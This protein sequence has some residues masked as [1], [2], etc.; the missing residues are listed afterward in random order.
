MSTCSFGKLNDASPKRI[1]GKGA[2]LTLTRRNQY[3][4]SCMH[5]TAYC[6]L[7]GRNSRIDIGRYNLDY[8]HDALGF[9]PLEILDIA[10][11]SL[12]NG[13]FLTS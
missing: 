12:R 8:D 2:E 7:P 6:L 13:S 3:H 4:S 9:E 11:R 1:K 5:T 10:D